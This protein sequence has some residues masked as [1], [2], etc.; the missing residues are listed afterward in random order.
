M[1]D[2]AVTEVL[3]SSDPFAIAAA[4]DDAV[5]TDVIMDVIVAFGD[6]EISALY[7]VEVK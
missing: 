5:D 1:T 2:A 7:N 6:H 3:A 4:Q